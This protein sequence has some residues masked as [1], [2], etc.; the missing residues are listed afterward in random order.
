MELLIVKLKKYT[1]YLNQYL[2][3][4]ILVFVQG[5]KDSKGGE[6]AAKRQ[7]CIIS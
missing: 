1:W 4:E 7:Y 5:K 6:Y 3:P 2:K